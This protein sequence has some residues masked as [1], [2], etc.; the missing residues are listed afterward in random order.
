MKQYLLLGFIIVL[1][2]INEFYL[3]NKVTSF[4]KKF[5]KFT[6][7]AILILSICSAYFAYKKNPELMHSIINPYIK[8]NFN[9]DPFN[10]ISNISLDKTKDSINPEINEEIII[11]NNNKPEPKYKRNVSETKKKHVAAGQHWKCENCKKELDASF[12]VHH[13]TPLYL[14]GDN[15]IE[16]LTALCRNCHGIETVKDKVSEIN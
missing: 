13:K 4:I 5:T 3:K 2:L 16:N 6:N 9:L 12:E 1:F 15:T 10:N 11:N 8:K 14:G 7:S